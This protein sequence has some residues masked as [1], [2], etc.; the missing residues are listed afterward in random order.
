MSHGY[1]AELKDA[2]IIYDDFNNNDVFKLFIDNNIIV[3]SIETKEASFEDFYLS[4]LGGRKN[5]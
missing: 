4:L 3:K 1:N 2:L 5:A